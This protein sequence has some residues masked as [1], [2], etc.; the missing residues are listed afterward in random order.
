MR[1]RACTCSLTS[2]QLHRCCSLRAPEA[3][4][5]FYEGGRARVRVRVRVRVIVRVR[6]TKGGSTGLYEK[7]NVLPNASR[8]DLVMFP[9]NFDHVR[10]IAWGVGSLGVPS[11]VSH[12]RWSLYHCPLPEQLMPSPHVQWLEGLVREQNAVEL[13]IAQRNREKKKRFFVVLLDGI[14]L[15][16]LRHV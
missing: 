10:D 1:T 7:T 15:A 12:P 14:S 9:C 2:F 16:F 6:R 3:A 5:G 11:M 4:T 8:V 13:E